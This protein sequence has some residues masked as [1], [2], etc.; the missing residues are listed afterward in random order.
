MP[1]QHLPH[2]IKDDLKVICGCVC[3]RYTEQSTAGKG[4]TSQG[5]KPLAAHILL[6]TAGV[7][8]LKPKTQLSPRGP[9]R[10]QTHV[11]VSVGKPAFPYQT[12]VLNLIV[13]LAQNQEPWMQHQPAERELE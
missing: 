11:H 7:A 8:R 3:C 6:P 13:C 1:V 12:F 10:V 2:A 5:M 9:Q 4:A